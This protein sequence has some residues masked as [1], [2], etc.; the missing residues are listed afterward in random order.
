MVLARE[1]T[2]VRHVMSDTNH[3]EILAY[4]HILI[5]L[6]SYT[7]DN[8]VIELWNMYHD[9]IFKFWWIYGIIYDIKN[10]LCEYRRD[11]DIRGGLGEGGWE[12]VAGG[13][14]RVDYPKNTIL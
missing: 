8:F 1:A 14:W 13:V 10:A 6:E 12:L 7:V 2:P 3:N 11:L 5:V 4:K 9:V